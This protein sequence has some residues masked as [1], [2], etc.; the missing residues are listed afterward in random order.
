MIVIDDKERLILFNKTAERMTGLKKGDVIG[1]LIEEMIPSSK[2]PRILKTKEVEM[3][4]E[5][6]LENGLKIITTRKKMLVH[7]YC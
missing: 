5:Q 4:Q 3:N 2:L 1:R 7:H 6:V